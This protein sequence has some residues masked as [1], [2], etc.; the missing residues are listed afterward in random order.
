MDVSQWWLYDLVVLAIAILCIWNGVSG[1]ALK[2]G[3]SLI[4]GIV[5]CIAGVFLS[6]PVSGM[7]YDAFLKD[8]MQSTITKELS[9]TDITGNIRSEL[10]SN[11]IYLPYDDSQ[12]ADMLDGISSDD[13]YMQQAANMIGIDI[14]D[15]KEQIEE[16]IGY[17]IETNDNIIPQW[18]SDSVK[19]SDG[20]ISIS[21]AAGTASA[22]L[23]DDYAGA[24]QKIEENYV[25]PVITG[26]LKTVI[27]VLITA[28]FSAI[29]RTVLIVLPN[30]KGSIAGKFIGAAFGA[31]KAAIY[32]YLMVLL[33]SSISSMQNGMYPFY[34]KGTINQ[35]YLF[36]IFYDMWR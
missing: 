26:V 9:N 8:T 16:S 11:G 36:R 27:F 25:K 19:G 21:A 1:G 14:D 20:K 10:E 32:L 24:S 30:R 34:S 15:L 18:V 28:I 3:S 33:V 2:S 12:I 22:I 17:A 29:L 4:I 6:G 13:Q 31:A 5:S 23:R 7:V 35:T